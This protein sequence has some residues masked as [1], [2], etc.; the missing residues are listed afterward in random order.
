MTLLGTGPSTPGQQ[1]NLQVEGFVA[2]LVPQSLHL[3]SCL[4]TE[5]GQFRPRVPHYQ[6]LLELVLQIPLYQISTSSQNVSQFQSVLLV[7]S[8]SPQPDPSYQT[9]TNEILLCSCLNFNQFALSFLALIPNK[10][11]H[12]YTFLA[13]KD[14]F[15]SPLKIYLFN[16]CEYTVAVFRQRALDP[17]TDGCE[18][19][20]RCWELNSGPLEEQSVLLTSE[21][22]LQPDGKLLI[23]IITDFFCQPN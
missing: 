4:V 17:I 16:V 15:F 13:C 20:C 1:D 10:L 5:D 8:P 12:Y 21:P 11:F 3:R 19:P 14:T 23:L 9:V 22:S 7:F 6:S 18:P 2:G